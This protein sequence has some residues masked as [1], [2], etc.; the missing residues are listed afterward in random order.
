MIYVLYCPLC[1]ESFE[2][3]EVKRNSLACPLC[4]SKDVMLLYEIKDEHKEIDESL[5]DESLILDQN[6]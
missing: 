1:D 5:L 3:T 6:T 4:K 2:K